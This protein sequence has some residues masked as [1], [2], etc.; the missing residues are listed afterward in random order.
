MKC[1]DY[2]DIDRS[3]F[4]MVM[5]NHPGTDLFEFVESHEFVDEVSCHVIFSQLVSAVRY[6]ARNRIVHRDIKDEN[7]LIDPNGLEI[8][9]IDFGSAVEVFGIKAEDVV[10]PKFCGTIK[11]CPP[12]A[13]END[14][15]RALPADIWAMG[16]LLFTLFHGG[17]PFSDIHE[18]RDAPLEFDPQ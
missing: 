15:F 13:I 6:L 11:Y 3:W 9:L 14:K 4:L 1:I 8:K 18:I 17:N 2:V 16:I 12:E 5:H 10:S 7:V